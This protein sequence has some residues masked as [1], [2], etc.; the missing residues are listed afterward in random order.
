MMDF[1]LFMC[2]ESHTFTWD[3]L[4]NMKSK[5]IILHYVIFDGALMNELIHFWL[6]GGMPNSVVLQIHEF[7]NEWV[8][9]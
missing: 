2:D 5:T 8:A 3:E 9:N 6:N 1:P 4:K 7:P